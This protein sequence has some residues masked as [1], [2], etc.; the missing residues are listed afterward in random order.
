MKCR[1]FLHGLILLLIFG[2]PLVGGARVALADTNSAAS[3]PWKL[4]L[5]LNDENTKVTFK[6]DST[7]HMVHGTTKNISGKIEL[8]D[9]SDPRSIHVELKLPVAKFD[10][11]NA[12]RDKKMR[13]VMGADTNPRVEVEMKTMGPGCEIENVIAEG[14]CASSLT[15]TISINGT[16]R[17]LS[18]PFEVM[19]DGAKS[20]NG[21]YQAKGEVDLL[22][23]AF[24]V[25]DP[26]I[27]IAKLDRTVHIAFEILIPAQ[28]TGA[29]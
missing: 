10:T 27:F 29:Y 18:L 24:N 20:G 16:V 25:R 14:R 1:K 3:L 9:K 15:G 2:L 7:W 28:G 17:E 23:D 4:P 6:V 19:F 22:W 26:S 13:D 21:V 8:Q 5:V 12:S 11:D